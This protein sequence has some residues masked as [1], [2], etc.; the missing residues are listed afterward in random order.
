M[1]PL[2][3]NACKFYRVLRITAIF[4]GLA[5]LFFNIIKAHAFPIEPLDFEAGRE[6][7][8]MLHEIEY[9]RDLDRARDNLERGEGTARDVDIVLNDYD[10]DHA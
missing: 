4:I 8:E 9:E 7:S 2:I 10:K 5:L 6:W 1:T 3:I